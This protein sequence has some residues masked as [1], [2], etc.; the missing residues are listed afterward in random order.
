MLE[1]FFPYGEVLTLVEATDVVR[2]E[3]GKAMELVV[4]MPAMVRRREMK[5]ARARG[6]SLVSA[7]SNILNVSRGWML[8]DCPRTCDQRQL[9]ESADITSRK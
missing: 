5:N 7:E 1:G 9:F 2:L 4:G 3:A 6:D 8:P